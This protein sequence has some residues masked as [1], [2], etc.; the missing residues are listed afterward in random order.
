MPWEVEIELCPVSDFWNEVENAVMSVDN[1]F[2]NAKAETGSIDLSSV[3]GILS[4]ELSE[5]LLVELRR[6]TGPLVGH[7]DAVGVGVGSG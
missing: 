4:R 3:G 2:R 6:N 7:G 5:N 1:H